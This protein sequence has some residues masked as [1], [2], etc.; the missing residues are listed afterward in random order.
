MS[1]GSLYKE[2]EILPVSST[3]NTGN[4]LNSCSPTVKTA[5]QEIH[6]FIKGEQDFKLSLL[7]LEDLVSNKYMADTRH[8]LFEYQFNFFLPNFVNL[9]QGNYCHFQK[10]W[11]NPK[12]AVTC[13][14]EAPFCLCEKYLYQL[15]AC[16]D[17]L[18]KGLEGMEPSTTKCKQCNGISRCSIHREPISHIDLLSLF[19]LSLVQDSK[20]GFTYDN[21]TPVD[22]SFLLHSS[23]PTGRQQDCK[24]ENPVTVSPSEQHDHKSEKSVRIS[25]SSQRVRRRK[26]NNKIVNVTISPPSP[27]LSQGSIPVTSSDQLPV[28]FDSSGATGQQAVDVAT[29]EILQN[30]SQMHC[31]IKWSDFDQKKIESLPPADITEL[32]ECQSFRLSGKELDFNSR[33]STAVLLRLADDKP[34]SCSILYDTAAMVSSL[35]RVLKNLAHQLWSSVHQKLQVDSETGSQVCPLLAGSIFFFSA[36]ENAQNISV[37]FTQNHRS[38]S[39]SAEIKSFSVPDLFVEKYKLQK[40]HVYVNN[41]SLIIGQNANSLMPVLL[42][43]N[44]NVTVY[45]DKI[46]LNFFCSRTADHQYI[47]ALS[48]IHI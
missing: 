6:S 38:I 46:N 47:P 37:V 48:L 44:Q 29:A 17:E 2:A 41:P 21:S 19:G 39:E 13:C 26:Q 18:N 22:L 40:K 20:W 27:V 8:E 32:L 10:L 23:P 4:I 30:S 34:F 12:I 25:Q 14:T 43:Q 11:A 45:W 3:S 42:E 31:D 1:P 24:I 16:L 15:L 5:L 9:K 28:T 35:P 36:N 7:K 33:L